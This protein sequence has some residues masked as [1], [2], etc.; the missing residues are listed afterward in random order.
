MPYTYQEILYDLFGFG[1][2]MHFQFVLSREESQGKG[3]VNKTRIFAR[4]ELKKLFPNMNLE[5]SLFMWSD[6]LEG[7]EKHLLKSFKLFWVRKVI[8]KCM[9]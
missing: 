3:Y 9:N 7:A 2:S 6:Y 5:I 8:L 4:K 1:Q